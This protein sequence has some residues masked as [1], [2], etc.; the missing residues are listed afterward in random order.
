[1]GYAGERLA[2]HLH[3]MSWPLLY[4]TLIALYVVIHYLFVSQTRRCSRRARRVSRS[5][6]KR[7][8]ARTADGIRPAVREQLFSVITRKAE[9]RTSSSASVSHTKELYRLGFL[10]TLAFLVFL[11]IERRGCSLITRLMNRKK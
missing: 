10:T 3:G 6:D 9:A 8:G 1:M 4:V 5:G 2:S 11:L 7:Q